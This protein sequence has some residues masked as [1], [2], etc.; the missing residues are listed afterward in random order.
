MTAPAA[1]RR[2][3][4]T[5]ANPQAEPT[6]AWIHAV[7]LMLLRHVDR[8]IEAERAGSGQADDDGRGQEEGPA[9]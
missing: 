9:R 4:F 6:A 3:V 2:A 5:V 7:A 8:Q 1:T